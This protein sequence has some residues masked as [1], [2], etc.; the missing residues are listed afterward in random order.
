M[1]LAYDGAAQRVTVS[2]EGARLF[3]DPAGG[4]VSLQLQA[5]QV[6]HEGTY[7]CSI[8][9]PQLQAQQAVEL[10][11]LREWTPPPTSP[12]SPPCA[13]ARPSPGLGGAGP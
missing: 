6:R 8:Y 12:L 10:R 11:I 4:N 1:I 5:A 13:A 9:L 2:E 3:L 7:I